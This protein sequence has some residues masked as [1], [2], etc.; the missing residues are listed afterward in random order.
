MIKKIPYLWGVQADIW[1]WHSFEL[2]N[3]IGCVML[4]EIGSVIY[5]RDHRPFKRNALKNLR[6]EYQTWIRNMTMTY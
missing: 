6:V 1:R 5:D 2:R 3:E 4:K